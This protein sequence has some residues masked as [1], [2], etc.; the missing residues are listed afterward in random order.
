MERPSWAPDEVDITAPS[1][2][3]VCDHFPGGSHDFASDRA[4]GPAVVGVHPAV[5]AL[6]RPDRGFLCRARRHHEG[7]GVDR[8]LDLGSGIPT[9][10]RERPLHPTRP[11]SHP[12]IA[13]LFGDPTVVPPGLVPIPDR[14]PRPLE[15]ADVRPEHAMLGGLGRRD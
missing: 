5:L 13:A 14:R 6:A 3:R 1:V 2:A 7:A 9:Y 10:A 11:R 15:E 8:F 4:S 12:D